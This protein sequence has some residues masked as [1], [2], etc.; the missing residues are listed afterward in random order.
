MYML[1]TMLCFDL[2]IQEDNLDEHNSWKKRQFSER[3]M[4]R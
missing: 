1:K 4:K 2:T 3:Q